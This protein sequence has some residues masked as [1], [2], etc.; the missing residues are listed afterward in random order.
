MMAG[1]RAAALE[2]DGAQVNGGTCG[3]TTRNYY[4]GTEMGD[5]QVGG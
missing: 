5:S 1:D 3:E 2:T 4:D